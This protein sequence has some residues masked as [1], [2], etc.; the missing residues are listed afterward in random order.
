MQI[1][2]TPIGWL[3]IAEHEGKL[4]DISFMDRKSGTRQQVSRLE[5]KTGI[6]LAGYFQKK[7]RCFNLPLGLQGTDFQLRVWRALSDIPFGEVRTYGQ[8]ARQL[9]SS[10]RAVGNAC[11]A[12]P[13]PIVIP[14]H[15]V[16]SA[17]GIGGYAGKISGS[18]LERKRWLLNH[19]GV[20]K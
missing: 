8:L 3:S 2:S 19:E 18:V 1:V 16:V 15:R 5:E 10:P 9:R 6:Q 20:I 14:C 4:A 7:T 12:N 13:L 11:R 17:Q